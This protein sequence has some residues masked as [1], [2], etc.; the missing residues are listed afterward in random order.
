M[1]YAVFEQDDT[2][3]VSVTDAPDDEWTVYIGR[4]NSYY[5]LPQSD[6]ANPFTL[7]DYTREAAVELY[8]LWFYYQIETADGFASQ[9]RELD[10]ETLACWCVPD[11]C[12]GEVLLEW[13]AT[14]EVPYDELERICASHDVPDSEVVGSSV[15]ETME[16]AMHHFGA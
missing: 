3:L 6:F 8:K 13:L 16:R 15:Q 11:A 5:G 10:G 14:E 7:D 2:R 4:E 12:H 9:A 1:E